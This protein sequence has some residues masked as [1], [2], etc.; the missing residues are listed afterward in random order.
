MVGESC[1]PHCY[2]SRQWD[3][4]VVWEGRGWDLDQCNQG[5]GIGEMSDHSSSVFRKFH[6]AS[7]AFL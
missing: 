1:W 7:P 4:K 2:I 6:L 5:D 3:Q